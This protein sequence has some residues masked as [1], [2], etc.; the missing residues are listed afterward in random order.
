MLFRSQLIDFE[1]PA[2]TADLLAWYVREY[3]PLLLRAPSTALFPGPA[4]EPKSAQTLAGQI[5]K[6]VFKRTGLTVNAHLFRHI[7]A[8]IYLDRNP[9]DYVTVQRVLG[10]KSL[11]TTTSIYTGMEAR[12]AGRHFV[13]VVRGRQSGSHP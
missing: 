13:D 6:T 5:I 8:K 9:G 2:D 4:G 1:L 11:N 10:H 12:A 3:R 7:A